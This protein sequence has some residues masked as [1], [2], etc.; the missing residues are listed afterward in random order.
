[1][2]VYNYKF[3]NLDKIKDPNKVK[4]IE[5]VCN[6]LINDKNVNDILES[7]SIFGSV[8]RGDDKDD[9]DIDFYLTFNISPID[10]N[11]I[12]IPYV[13]KAIDIIMNNV[14]W[15]YG[16]DVCIKDDFVKYGKLFYK[17]L[18]RDKL[19]IYDRS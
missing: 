18:E 3:K 1:M 17:N 11:Y 16:A 2:N 6:K 13:D 15:K 8:A 19:T 14:P 12:Y 9:S 4:V 5:N 7:I 10:E